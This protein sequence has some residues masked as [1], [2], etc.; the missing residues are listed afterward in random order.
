MTYDGKQQRH[1]FTPTTKLQILKELLNTSGNR[2][3]TS[4]RV[5][6]PQ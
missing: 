2:K 1:H 6:A 5:I 4:Y 3:G